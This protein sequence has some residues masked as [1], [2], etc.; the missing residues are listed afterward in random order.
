M[1]PATGLVVG[2]S[3]V[4]LRCPELYP[5]GWR[6][7]ATGS[8]PQWNPTRSKNLKNRTDGPT[9]DQAVQNEDQGTG[10]GEAIH[11]NARCKQLYAN[12]GLQLA[13]NDYPAQPSGSAERGRSTNWN[14]RLAS[15]S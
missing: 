6:S 13:S 7:D 2:L 3:A 5:Q 12:T 1:V 9:T 14:R 4:L 8:S 10:W 15:G 11:L